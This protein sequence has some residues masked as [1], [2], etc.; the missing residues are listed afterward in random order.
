[1]RLKK[2]VIISAAAAVSAASLFGVENVEV[3]FK[4]ANK[5]FSAKTVALADMPDGARRL[6]LAKD[7]IPEE[8][9]FVGIYPDSAVAQKGDDGYFIFSRG[10]YLNF[11]RD[12]YWFARTSSVMP[13]FGAKTPKET[14]VAVA[15]SMRDEYSVC[16]EVKRGVHK[17]F[18][19]FKPKDIVGGIYED[20]VFDFYTLKG[21]DANYSGMG[22]KY[23]QIRLQNGEISPIRERIKTDRH[24]AE[25]WD[26]I[27]AR[28]VV[29]GVLPSTKDENPKFDGEPRVNVL[30]TFDRQKK[31]IDAVKSAGIPEVVLVLAGW[32]RGGF[33]GCCPDIFPIPQELGGEAKLRELIAYAKNAGYPLTP[34]ADHTCAY[35]C[36]KMFSEDYVLKRI[37]GGLC[38]MGLFGGGRMHYICLKRAW[39][40]FIAEQMRQIKDLGFD[41][42]YYID[43]FSAR[44]P[45]PCADANHFA[46]RREIA[47]VQN[48][49]F[50]QA[51]K[52][53]GA[54]YSE[55]GHDHCI[56]S[57]DGANYTSGMDYFGDVLRRERG[58]QPLFDGIYPL[59]EIVYHGVILST[60]GRTTQN[61]VIECFFKKDIFKDDTS[62]DPWKPLPKGWLESPTFKNR[63]LRLAEWG[64]RPSI[65]EL[66][67][68]TVA[69]LAAMYKFYE[70]YKRLQLEFM[71]SHEE[72]SKGVFL[73]KYSDGTDV[74]VNYTQKPFVYRGTAV[75]AESYK[76]FSPAAKNFRAKIRRIAFRN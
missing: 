48:E 30:A 69:E 75:A 56:Q 46:T 16:A 73:V 3:V 29:C 45:D 14:F 21:K 38:K 61:N 59:W 24:L 27:L 41:G 36:A 74:I 10:E 65:Y 58:Q 39:P 57:I 52:T 70:G 23:R 34:N 50:V 22:R 71:E 19:R 37:D 35:R 60:P 20:I 40:L 4:K 7:E 5:T 6:V 47:A 9:D 31:I 11:T 17:M 33:N 63:M 12:K 72:I 8:A 15:K 43:V 26:R 64:A 32:Q 28:L 76:L 53:F 62:Y 44:A 54:V 13:V 51:R 42:S 67:D 66:T 25:S 1:M 2:L 55:G 68:S 49:I 18:A